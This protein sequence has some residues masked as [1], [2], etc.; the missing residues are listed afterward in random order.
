MYGDH[1]RVR[2]VFRGNQIL[3]Y[4]D[5]LFRSTPLM[6][7]QRVITLIE[8]IIAV[9]VAYSHLKCVAG[10]ASFLQTGRRFSVDLAPMRS[11]YV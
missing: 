1:C 8:C 5:N 2:D 4:R 6:P 11:K 3:D 7:V 10:V 9:D